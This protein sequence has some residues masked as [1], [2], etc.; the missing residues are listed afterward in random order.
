MVARLNRASR[1][2]GR[3]RRATN[4]TRSGWSEERASSKKDEK[5]PRFASAAAKRVGG[6]FGLDDP[7]VDFAK[8]FLS[9]TQTSRI[10][11]QPSLAFSFRAL[12]AGWDDFGDDAIESG[13]PV[14]CTDTLLV[15]LD[16]GI[17]SGWPRRR[18]LLPC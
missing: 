7:L 18:S 5:G 2:E 6:M 8:S 11:A 17:T 16:G 9:S 13:Y 12:P 14:L 4:G 1:R 15:V 3:A 10:A